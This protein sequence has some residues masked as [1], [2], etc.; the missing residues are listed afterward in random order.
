MSNTEAAAPLNSRSWWNEYFASQ[1][2]AYDGRAQTAYFMQRLVQGLPAPE[3]EYLASHEATVLDWG[4]ALG[5]GVDVLGKTF[6]RCRVTGMDFAERA[7]AE[8]QRCFPQYGFRHTTNGEIGECFDVIVTSNCLEHFTDPLPIMRQ[9]LQ[10]CRSFYAIL[11]PYRE[12]PLHS[13]HVAQF[14]EECFP[15][16][17]GDFIR[18]AAS[19][20]DCE[21]PYW[22]GRQLLVIYASHAYLQERERCV[23]LI[24]ERQKWN[25]YYA[26]LPAL[27]M[28]DA[29]RQF[30]PDAADRIHELLPAGGRVL[31]AGCGA[32]YQSI[33][34]AQAGKVQLSLMDFSP[35][36]LGYAERS[37]AERRLSADFV[38]QDVFS[39]GEPEYD[40]VFNA[41]VLEHYAFDQQVAFLRGMA[42]R[43]RKFVLA[44]V[45]NPVCY[46]YWLSRM[47]QACGGQWPYGKETPSNDLSAAFEAAGL[48]FLGQCFGGTEGT[49]SVIRN[50]AGI[51]DR[52]REEMLTVHRSPL[53]PQE[54]RAYLVAALGCK[55]EAAAVPVCWEKTTGA[56]SFTIDQLTASVADALATAVAAQR[57]Q[58]QLEQQVA[59]LEGAK[60]QLAQQHAALEQQGNALNAAIEQRTDELANRD[61]QLKAI[62]GSRAWRL[63]KKWRAV[64]C[65]VLPC[66]SRRESALRLL[67]RGARSLRTPWA[68]IKSLPRRALYCLP[69]GLQHR[70]SRRIAGRGGLLGLNCCAADLAATCEVDG[71]VSVVL[72]VYNHAGLLREAVE[73]VLAQTY[74]HFELIVVNDGS[75]DGVEKVLAEYVGHPQVRILTQPNQS[76]P[77]ALSNGFEFARGE[78]WT[79]TSAD[80][81]MHPDQLRR[82]VAFLRAN[83]DVGMVY[84]DYMAVDDAG[85]PLGDVTFRPHNRRTPHDPNIHLPRDG[86]SFGQ[87]ADNFIGPCFLYRGWIGR[88]LGDYDPIQGIED[89]DYWL[90]LSLVARIAHLDTDEPLYRYRVHADSL[91]GRAAEL[92]I[93]EN[94]LRLMDY[95]QARKEFHAKPWTIHADAATLA[96]LSEIDAAPNR[97]VPWSG[98][99]VAAGD[100]AKCMLL[101]H[102]E[103]LPVAAKSHRSAGVVLAAWFPN[104]AHATDRYR[105]EAQGTADVC[106]A[107]DD[108]TAARL[109]LL[110]RHVF[111]AAPGPS[112]LAL[113]TQWANGR[114]FF[115]ATRSPAERARTL[116]RMFHPEGRTPRVLLQADN[117]TQGGMEQVVIDLARC[118]RG[119]NFDVSLLILGEQG[120]D[121]ARVQQAGIPVLRLP[122]E[123]RDAH[124]RRLLKQRQIDIVN[125][126]Y[127]LYGAPIAAALRIPFVQTIHNA[128]VFLSREGVTAYRANDRFTSAYACVSQMAAH[129]ADAKLALPVSKMILAPNGIDISRLDAAIVEGA[130]QSLRRELGLTADNFVFLNVGSHQPIKCQA[131]L[132]DAFAE[133]ARE[134]PQAR[135]ALV[136]RTLIPD[137]FARVQQTIARHGL[138]DRVLVTGHRADAA[139]FYAAADAFVLPSLSEGWSLA[140]AEAIVAGLPVVATSVGSA[141]D[142]LPQIG[143]RLIRPPFGAITDLDYH[144]LEKYAANEAPAFVEE[145][146]A[147]MKDLCQDRSRP[148]VPDALRRAFDCR[149]AYKPYGQLFLWLLQGGQPLAARPWTAAGL[150]S[151]PALPRGDAAAA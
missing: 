114:T 50:L 125:A 142:L 81:A 143:G 39:P 136:G 134:F 26:A 131:A 35:E 112:L 3:R 20:V 77:K 2:D 64:R 22:P 87:T 99:R 14:R 55:G 101:V 27:D 128:Y 68:T 34:L 58:T 91:S 92:N 45:P 127:S 40:L 150:A 28:D 23:R 111:R 54:Q 24:S 94:A 121:A 117:F 78:F 16:R 67:W 105:A 48:R 137:Y 72:P 103:S 146:A 31:E 57:R 38:C 139:R 116:P 69:Y 97:V 7:I 36:A 49:E 123:N 60:R 147:A 132:V 138:E 63:V 98:Q 53:I 33:A 6:P 133:V 104:D 18:I 79:W 110:S 12:S 61:R 86:G 118:L 10:S 66:G 74:R 15:E 90:R 8:A 9:H 5:N 43:S 129:Y 151:S 109:A 41:G 11:V 29:L 82:Q 130:R 102:A 149:E 25:N 141:P 32:G 148:L 71:L 42:S 106:F 59:A 56:G 84:A 80:N 108:N 75:R 47:H 107:E 83:A 19:A 119:E 37:F 126:H 144:T 21:L 4:C 89:F 65:R 51:D 70:I 76:L 115:E 93:S 30:G 52:L 46:W 13:S 122:R 95:H 124:Y 73:S 17:I 100:D 120:K 96:W 1:W 135:L 62:T 44:L 140:M 85:R 145:L 113:A 88:L